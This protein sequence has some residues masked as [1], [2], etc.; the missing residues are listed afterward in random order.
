MRE[1]TF[2]YTVNVPHAVTE[3]RTR[4]V[5][6][7]VPVTKTRTIQV[8]VPKTT[9]QMRYQGLRSLGKPSG[10]KFQLAVVAMGKRTRWPVRSW[11][12]RRHGSVAAADAAVPRHVRPAAARA[13]AD[14]VRPVAAV[15]GGAG[16]GCT[17]TVTKKVWV[18][19][20]MTENVPVTTTSTESQT[21]HYTVYEQQATAVPYECTKVVYRCE[22]R[23]GTK[24]VCHYVDETRTRMRKVVKYNEE[25]RTRM[26]KQL[27]Y[28][29]VTKTETVP[30]VSFT[31][32]QRTKE[33][34]YTYN[35]PNTPRKLTKSLVT[36]ASAKTKSKS[37]PFV[38]L[39]SLPRSNKFKSVRW[40]LA[41]SKKPSTHAAMEAHQLPAHRLAADAA[42][43]HLLH[44][45]VGAEPP[46]PVVAEAKP[47]QILSDQEMF[48]VE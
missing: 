7:A 22:Q 15:R 10:A 48:A 11:T 13:A 34:S 39:T 35:V 20:V 1:E 3:Q 2:T 23:T 14:A 36:T 21:V 37:T 42:L 40:F 27:N 32:E 17:T 12:A 24:Q 4:M 30:H 18:P 28:Q 5:T 16:G 41:W 25:K 31:T 19:N 33:V 6:N 43:P 8:C 29:T 45:V 38:F 44:L 46:R 9:M 47:Q 26:R